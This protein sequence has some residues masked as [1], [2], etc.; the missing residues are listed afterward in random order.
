MHLDRVSIYLC[1]EIR[2]T[3]FEYIGLQRRQIHVDYVET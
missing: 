2:G 1:I 3:T